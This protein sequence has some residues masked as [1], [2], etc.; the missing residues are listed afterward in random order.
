MESTNQ[1]QDSKKKSTLPLKE[2]IAFGSG[3]FANRY[4]ENGVND[5]ATPVYNI[6]LGLSPATI[7]VVLML[8]R[9]WDSITDPIMGW[10]SDNWRGTSGRR[11]PF[12]LFG[13]ILM[14]I[15]YP[16]I[17]MASPD[18][19][20]QTKSIYFICFALIFFTTY[21]IY[22]VPFRALATE[23]TPDYEE[24]TNI[25]IFSAFFNKLFMFMLPW[26]FPLSQSQLFNDPVTGI[27]TLA[28]LSSLLILVSG[29]VCAKFPQER[30]HKVALQ[31][32]RVKLV[33]SFLSLIKDPA[34]LLLHGIGVFLLSS[35]LLVATFGLYVNMF[36]VWE[37]DVA[38]GS[39]YFAISQNILQILGI[40]MLAVISKYLVKIEKKKLISLSL[41]LAL[42]GSL[43][44]WFTYNQNVPELL[45]I[46]PFFFAPAYT[47]FWAIFLS[48]LGDYCDYDEFKNGKRR[49][50]VFSAI[51]G[52]IMKAGS[53][54]AFGASGIL[55]AWTHFSKDLGGDQPDGTLLKMRLLLIGLPVLC[56]LLAIAFNILYPLSK[57]RMQ[58]IRDTLESRRGEI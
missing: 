24:R 48:M 13:S 19:T 10:V 55:L 6:I 21:T 51:S 31:Q 22:S 52:W 37:G 33:P 42:L 23:M 5:I 58:E 20:E 36:Y 54:L 11:K 2:K 47:V 1:Q 30:Y 8:M 41:G 12:L 7:G 25:R 28:G 43:A 45:F 40:I 29:I 14:A 53:S 26:I 18:W 34:F 50:G 17:W 44:R 15:S 49:E 35:I 39:Q 57:A 4:G 38:G 3:E 9:L 16:L 46:D 27:R 56:L 32:E